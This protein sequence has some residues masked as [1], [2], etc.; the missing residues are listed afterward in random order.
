M[1]YSVIIAEDEAHNRQTLSQIL[2]GHKDIN[3]IAECKDG[4]ET[5]A[6]IQKHPADLLF[7]DINMPRLSGFEV[8]ELLGDQAPVVIFVTAFDEHAL[9]AFETS[10]IDYVLKPISS[11]RIAR[12]LDKFRK[13]AAGRRSYAEFIENQ[14]TASKSLERLIVKDGD[15]IHVIPV[16][17]IMYIKA[18]DDYVLIVT[19][20]NKY[21]KQDRLSALEAALDKEQFCRIH[22]SYILNLRYLIRL[23]H[24]G[25]ET[26][27]A[28]LKN[29]N[30]VPVS[31]SGFHLLP[32][33]KKKPDIAL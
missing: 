4:F 9:R 2:S 10:A 8:L 29:G 5:V 31:A 6:A 32:W 3:I 20:K 12:A 33:F 28:I 15:R 11:E 14:R 30:L 19:E 7:L 24:I 27:Q 1:S 26:Y 21:V 22:R 18:E 16:E 23:E 17:D 25:K 13:N